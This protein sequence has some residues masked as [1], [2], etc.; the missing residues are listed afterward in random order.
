[1]RHILPSLLFSALCLTGLPVFAQAEAEGDDLVRLPGQRLAK[2]D[3][4]PAQ[5]NIGRLVPG[6]GLFAS[7]DMNDDGIITPQEL[8]VGISAAF[9][10]ADANADGLLVAL[11]QLDWAG[12]LAT[13]DDTLSNPVRFDP[14]LDRVVT[15]EE[16]RDVVAKLA[17]S[18]QEPDGRI[19]MARLSA[20]EPRPDRADRR[21]PGGSQ[22]PGRTDG[23]R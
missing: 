13:R 6:G 19:E 2:P 18:Y 20:A 10:A 7:F 4:A 14:N 16:F 1:M 17:A 3:S 8:E 11:E 12:G 21:P 9:Q 5:R 22:P 23:S 15:F